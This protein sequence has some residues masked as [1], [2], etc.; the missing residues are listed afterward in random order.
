MNDTNDRHEPDL[1]DDDVPSENEESEQ[2]EDEEVEKANKKPKLS[3][4]GELQEATAA[5]K[6]DL[7]DDYESLSEES[8]QEDD[9]KDNEKVKEMETTGHQGDGEA[10]VL[11]IPVASGGQPESVRAAAKEP[12]PTTPVYEPP[13]CKC[14][15]SNSP[16]GAAEPAA[17]VFG[18]LTADEMCRELRRDMLRERMNYNM[19]FLDKRF[20]NDREREKKISQSD[21]TECCVCMTLV[22]TSA[23]VPCGHLCVCDDCAG[24][25]P[26]CELHTHTHTHTHTNTH[27]DFIMTETAPICPCCSTATDSVLRIYA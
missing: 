12:C 10:L 8:G 4:V 25:L 5:Y 1:D 19:A 11:R 22:K 7:D 13:E 27:T 6:A 14:A 23:F 3:H 24:K 21:A 2:E 20:E 18:P 26:C 9:E 17:V 15:A 16:R